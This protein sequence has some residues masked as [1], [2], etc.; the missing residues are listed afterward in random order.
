MTQKINLTEKQR[1]LLDFIQ[2]HFLS[3]NMMPTYTDMGKHFGIS[4]CAI[5]K[6]LMSLERRGWIKRPGS[7]MRNGLVILD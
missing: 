1:E 2:A 5:G 3:Q 4:K 6:R 7:G